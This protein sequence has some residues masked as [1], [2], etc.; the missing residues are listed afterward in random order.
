MYSTTLSGAVYG[1]NSY[2]VSVEVDIANG[3]PGIDMVGSLSCEVKEAKERV[4]VALNNSG[5]ALP[6][7]HITINLSPANVRKDGS[8]FDLPIAIGILKSMEKIKI[9]NQMEDALFIGELGLGGEVRFSAGILP[10]ILEAKRKGIR[11]CFVP[12]ANR[13]EA[14][15]VDEVI[16]YGVRSLQEVISILEGRRTLK[17]EPESEREET[18]GEK[19]TVKEQDA[20]GQEK[21]LDF[22][23]IRGQEILKKAALISAAGFHHVLIV[24]PPGVGK[25]MIA[26]RMPTILPPMSLEECLEVTKIYSVSGLI[27]E[28]HPLIQ[29]RPFMNPHHTISKQALS[30]GGRIPK[31]GVISLAHKGVLFLDELPEFK[32]DT[33]DVMRQPLEDKKVQIARS[34]GTYDYPAD[35]ILF[36]A[37]NPCPCG[38]YPNKS[39]CSCTPVQI[40]NYMGHISGPLLDRMDLCVQAEP[41]DITK[42]KT[43]GHEISS[44]EMRER[45]LTARTRQLNR[46]QGTSIQFNSQLE[47]KAVERFCR[48]GRQEQEL[49]EEIVRQKQFSARAYY[50]TLKVARTIADLED[51][52]NIGKK[53]LLE[54]LCYRN[55]KWLG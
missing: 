33:L 16:V 55:E 17:P 52:E 26:K 25:T 32:R 14:Q 49:F 6:A 12:Y 44:G 13:K 9:T 10:V 3:L 7:S 20:A 4:R 54:A 30:G 50:R 35:F 51:C 1:I 2:L 28:E 29:E 36:A 38:Y 5:Y 11:H 19:G 47:G 41:F 37:L 48:L 23:Q 15:V 34:L 43:S 46:F 24:G 53:H 40:K 31:P 22:S 42:N 39:K 21:K 8:A 27:D 18:T 45:V